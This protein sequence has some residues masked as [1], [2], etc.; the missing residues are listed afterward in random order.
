MDTAQLDKLL[1]VGPGLVEDLDVD[2]VLVRVLDV[3]RELTAARYAA[4]GV[5]DE[6]GVGLERF[7]TVGLTD[8]ERAHI[9][10]LPRGR[11]VLGELIRKPE[12]LRLADVGEHPSS[13]GFPAGHPPM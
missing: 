10:D 6:A 11:G 9:G 5:L 4:L 13:Y 8:D 7:I 3:A 12:P 1:E 2:A